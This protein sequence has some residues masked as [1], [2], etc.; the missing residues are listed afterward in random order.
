MKVYLD[1][2]FLENFIINISVLY[3]TSIFTKTKVGKIKLIL[4]SMFLSII[5]VIRYL[6][7]GD[8]ILIQIL[9]ISIVIY[10]LY[11]PKNIVKYVKLQMYFYLIYI[12]YIGIIIST[13]IF[14]SI[15]L[16]KISVRII[17]YIITTFITYAINKYMWKIWISKIKSS[18]LTYKV[19]INSV[20]KVKFKVFVDTGNNL[21]DPFRNL[22]VIILNSTSYFVKMKRSL[23]ERNTREI[24]FMDILTA[25]G[26][27]K[28]KGYI[29]NNISIMKGGIEK[30]LLQKAIIVF[31][32]EKI[33]NNEYERN[34]KL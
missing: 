23:L 20:D 26:K 11:F 2:I 31:I 9:S 13:S 27:S 28:I 8:N 33:N 4:L 30:V 3:Q 7:I 12:M 32:D 17:L 25:T 16:N 1:Y 5:S 24:V 22:D 29:F 14:F 19:V 15:N 34:N 21:T 10:L 18:S 6:K